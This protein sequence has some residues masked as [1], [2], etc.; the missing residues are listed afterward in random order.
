M[1]LIECLTNN[2]ERKTPPQSPSEDLGEVKRQKPNA[3]QL[4]ATESWVA[5]R[6]ARR[7]NPT[8]PRIDRMIAELVA[9]G[10]KQDGNHMV[11]P[12]GKR[13]LLHTSDDGYWR[14]VFTRNFIRYPI[15]LSRFICWKTY[16]P[17][18][19]GKPFCDHINRVRGDN[20]PENLRWVSHKENARNISPET[21]LKFR[22]RINNFNQSHPRLGT[23]RHTAKLDDSKVME[24]RKLYATGN[25]SRAELARMFGV[26]ENV[27][28]LAIKGKTWKYV[29][30]VPVIRQRTGKGY[31]PRP[32]PPVARA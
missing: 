5:G 22:N 11:W 24:M 25:Y 21:I 26:S 18:P 7:T 3:R 19:E 17:A 13:L 16:G 20:R 9:V 31:Y 4:A 2:T 1:N 27:G 10:V 32:S 30:P 6:K 12:D 29:P 23:E 8:S 28:G 15:S 14:F